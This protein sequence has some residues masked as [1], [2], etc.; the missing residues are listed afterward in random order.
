MPRA[1][2]GRI[3]PEPRRDLRLFLV[4]DDR[5]NAR[6]WTVQSIIGKI[7]PQRNFCAI[8]G[9]IN[10]ANIANAIATGRLIQR[11]NRNRLSAKSAEP[12]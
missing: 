6:R 2:G 10:N 12:D 8:G 1:N 7:H 3:S 4:R 5:Q 11:Q 9:L